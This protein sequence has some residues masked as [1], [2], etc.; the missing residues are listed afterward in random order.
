MKKVYDSRSLSGTN[1][2]SDHRIVIAKIVAKLPAPKYK[3]IDAKIN[4]ERLQDLEISKQYKNT[5]QEKL[6]NLKDDKPA[7]EKWHEI[8][9][10]NTRN[11]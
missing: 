11:I 4:F 7:Q 5:V 6:S 8:V 1:T 3:K 10:N 2:N 9:Q